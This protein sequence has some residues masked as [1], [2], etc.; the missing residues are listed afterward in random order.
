[1]PS[2]TEPWSPW[3]A[4]AALRCSMTTRVGVEDVQAL[5]VGDREGE[6][7]VGADGHD[8][9]DA[10]LVGELLVLLTEGRRDVHDAGAVVGRD[11]V[12]GEHDVRLRVAEVVGE[13]RGVA[14]ARRGRCP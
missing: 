4:V 1:M 7:A 10:V 12:G 2:V 3:P 8:R 5:V 6:P 9:R 13:R 11:V 14:S